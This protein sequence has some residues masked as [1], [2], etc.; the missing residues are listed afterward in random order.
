MSLLLF[1]TNEFGEASRCIHYHVK[2]ALLSTLLVRAGLWNFFPGVGLSGLLC[3]LVFYGKVTVYF[4]LVF[5]DKVPLCYLLPSP[6]YNV[7]Y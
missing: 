7:G 5:K 1:N 3:S 6:G 2:G 4:C